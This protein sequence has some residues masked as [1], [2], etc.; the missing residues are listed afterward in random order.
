MT[1]RAAEAGMGGELG[2]Q[3]AGGGWGGGVVEA[4][5]GKRGS[6]EDVGGL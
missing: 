2:V 4:C 5:P 3:V 1:W 6:V